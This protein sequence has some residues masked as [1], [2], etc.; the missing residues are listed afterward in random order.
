MEPSD[1]RLDFPIVLRITSILRCLHFLYHNNK[2]QPVSLT[3]QYQTY[4]GIQMVFGW[5][6]FL[7]GGL[8]PSLYFRGRL[9][10]AL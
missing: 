9:Q 10:Q 8:F 7:G 4:T 2:N 1:A 5:P 6:F 3:D